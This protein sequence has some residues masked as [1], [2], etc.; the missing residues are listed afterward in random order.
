MKRPPPQVEP[1]SYAG[2]RTPDDS[3]LRNRLLALVL[4]WLAA[5]LTVVAWAG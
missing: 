5:W 4:L 2:P 3:R 1:L